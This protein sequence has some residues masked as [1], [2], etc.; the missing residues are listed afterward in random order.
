MD[1][2]WIGRAFKVSSRLPIAPGMKVSSSD[3]NPMLLAAEAAAAERAMLTL[4]ATQ[5]VTKQQAAAM[6]DLIKAVPSGD[7]GR[8]ITAYA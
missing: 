4:K 2:C 8:L 7:T 5:D 6:V 3:Q 1:S